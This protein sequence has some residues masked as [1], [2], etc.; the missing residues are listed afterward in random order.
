MSLWHWDLTLGCYV[1]L[2]AQGNASGIINPKQAKHV[3][4]C[5]ELLYNPLEPVRICFLTFLLQLSV[6]AKVCE[7][8]ISQGGQQCIRTLQQAAQ[9]LT[10]QTQQFL[11]GLDN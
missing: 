10:F 6:C 9:S 11:R 8:W 7:Q 3:F 2:L 1:R 5:L 4:R